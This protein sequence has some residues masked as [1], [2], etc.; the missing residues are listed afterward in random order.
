MT[1]KK[2]LWL[3][4]EMVEKLY[5]GKGKNCRCGCAGEYFRAKDFPDKVEQVLH[6]MASGYREV[7]SIKDYIFEIVVDEENDIVNTIYLHR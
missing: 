2:S 6:L 3:E 1:H 5:V 7:S 4:L